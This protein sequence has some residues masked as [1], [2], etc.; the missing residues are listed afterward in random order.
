MSFD[1]DAECIV[2]ISFTFVFVIIKTLVEYVLSNCQQYNCF[3]SLHIFVFL[4]YL[5]M[6]TSII[7]NCQSSCFCFDILLL[8]IVI[9]NAFECT[10]THLIIYEMCYNEVSS[11]YFRKKDKIRIDLF[12]DH[13]KRNCL[14]FSSYICHYDQYLKCIFA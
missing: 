12:S 3:F 2:C 10:Y 4:N 6:Y 13:F 7:K 11:L 8:L 9:L 1:I 14:M 5:N